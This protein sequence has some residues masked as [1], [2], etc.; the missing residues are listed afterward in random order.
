MN[1]PN[2]R[3]QGMQEDWARTQK[4]SQLQCSSS[5]LPSLQSRPTL[6]LQYTLL[7][8]LLPSIFPSPPQYWITF[9]GYYR[10]GADRSFEFQGVHG[11]CCFSFF[12]FTMPVSCRVIQNTFLPTTSKNIR[13]KKTICI[14]SL[15]LSLSLPLPNIERVP[16]HQ[17]L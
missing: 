3:I 2:A 11:Y 12:H 8:L 5:C 15:S 6:H 9:Q 7:L 13:T 17:I 14:S 16:N 1:G 4:P 10:W